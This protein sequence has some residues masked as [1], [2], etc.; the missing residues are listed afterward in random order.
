MCWF[1]YWLCYVIEE[2][3]KIGKVRDFGKDYYLKINYIEA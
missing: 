1:G 2:I 3:A